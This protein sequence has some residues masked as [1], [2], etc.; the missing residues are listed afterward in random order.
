[1]QAC[2]DPLLANSGL[3]LNRLLPYVSLVFA[4]FVNSYE[5]LKKKYLNFSLR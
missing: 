3:C 5:I 1:M 2:V 4:P